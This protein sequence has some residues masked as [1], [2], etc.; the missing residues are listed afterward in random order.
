MEYHPRERAMVWGPSH[1]L[2]ENMSA[3][4]VTK[5][6]YPFSFALN[7]ERC[8]L[9]PTTCMVAARDFATTLTEEVPPE[10]SGQHPD[11]YQ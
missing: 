8:S 3:N 10:P 2:V 6:N 1:C 7:S 4:P 11:K 5:I 9:M